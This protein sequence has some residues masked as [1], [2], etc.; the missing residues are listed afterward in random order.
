VGTLTPPTATKDAAAAIGD[1]LVDTAIVSGG[2]ATWLT[3]TPVPNGDAVNVVD[4]TGD[5]TLYDGSAGVALAC[6]SVGLG[7]GRAE[8][9][10][11]AVMAARH[12]AGCVER[13]RNVGLYDGLA[14][15]GLASLAVGAAAA[16]PALVRAGEAT[17][18]AVEDHP[19]PGNDIVSGMAGVAVAFARAAALTDDDRWARAARNAADQLVARASRSP[20]GWAWRDRAATAAI[21]LCGLAHGVAGALWALAEVTPLLDG[22]SE[23][24]GE[25]IAGGR[26]YELSFF[27]PRSNR[28]PDLRDRATVEETSA[29]PRPDWWCH[30]SVGIGLS[31]LALHSVR[32]HPALLA[33]VAAALQSSSAAADDELAG[34]PAAGLTVCHGVGGVV[35]LLLEC[36]L[37]MPED[38]H[39]ECARSLI[40]RALAT[41]GDVIEAWPGGVRGRPGPGLMN[42][43]AG[44]MVL[45]ARAADPLAIPGVGLLGVAMPRERADQW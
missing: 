18:A 7:T 10:E 22:D 41:V 15:V 5:P 44:T 38:I 33:E 31:R 21:P 29:A 36:H 37:A 17:L 16:E 3:P 32:P 4:R 11:L 9:V 34:R 23:A 35:D 1:V 13:V 2:E 24:F 45:L 28:W 25:A 39:L 6:A 43:L 8:L 27:D 20:W 42:G 40:D 19:P 12:A 14:G 26:Q 30:G